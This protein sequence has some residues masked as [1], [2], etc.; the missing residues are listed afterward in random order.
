MIPILRVL[1]QRSRSAPANS[2]H[3]GNVQSCSEQIKI[4][5]APT[6]LLR[7]DQNQG[8]NPWG[9]FLAGQRRCNTPVSFT[10]RNWLLKSFSA[11]RTTAF[12]YTRSMAVD[13]LSCICWLFTSST[14][15]TPLDDTET[16]RITPNMVFFVDDNTGICTDFKPQSQSSLETTSTVDAIISR[17]WNDLL[18]CSG[19]GKLEHIHSV[20]TTLFTSISNQTASK[21][22]PLYHTPDTGKAVVE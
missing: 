20:P 4:I 9:V 10:D 5:H 22:N 6:G 8:I 17:S 19:G 16:V 18:L 13:N 14:L 7:R 1:I 2:A 12:K 15:C 11:T 21:V 3:A